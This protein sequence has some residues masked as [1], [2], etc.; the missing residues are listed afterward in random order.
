VI[1][2]YKIASFAFYLFFHLLSLS[3]FMIHWNLTLVS[4][5]FTFYALRMGAASLACHRYFAHRY[6][7]VGRI[8]QFFLGLWATMPL[9]FG[10]LWWATYHRKHH[11]YT[12]TPNDPHRLGHTHWI[13]PHTMWLFAEAN[14]AY[15]APRDFAQYPELEWIDR[16]YWLPSTLLAAMCVWLFGVVSL[17]PTVILSS[18]ACWHATS[19]LNSFAHHGPAIAA[20]SHP[21]L[22]NSRWLSIFTFGEGYHRNHHLDPAYANNAHQVDQFDVGYSLLKI[23]QSFGF[24]K[25]LK[26]IK[27]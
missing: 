6:Y 3:A 14:H 16:F 18:V 1:K 7:E 15:K 2:E 27:S 17:I 19:L 21:R 8:R 26:A 12:D 20:D 9:Q 22:R 23:A 25:N 24:I 13:W 5:F 10:P 4:L 11:A